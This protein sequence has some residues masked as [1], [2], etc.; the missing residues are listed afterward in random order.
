M[1][2][3]TEGVTDIHPA[4]VEL[5]VVNIYTSQAFAQF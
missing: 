5:P 2:D 1:V 4:L 3:C